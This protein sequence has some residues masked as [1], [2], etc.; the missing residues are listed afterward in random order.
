MTLLNQLKSIS[1]DNQISIIQSY[2]AVECNEYEFFDNNNRK[3]AYIVE[4]FNNPI[5]NT[6]LD[7]PVYELYYNNDNATNN[8]DNDDFLASNEY[9]DVDFLLKDISDYL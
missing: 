9:D 2:S 3:I 5:D 8:H 1:E 6:K 4:Y 7:Y